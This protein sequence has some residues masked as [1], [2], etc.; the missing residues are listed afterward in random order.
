MK[1]VMLGLA[2]ALSLVA[3]QASAADAKGEIVTAATHAGYASQAANIDGVHMHLHHT[4]N[5]LVGPN[6]AGFDAKELNPCAHSGNGA[7]PDTTDAAKK[8]KLQAAADKAKAGIAAT[9]IAT[10]K[11]D[12]T[13][14]ESM[15]KAD[16]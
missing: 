14:V 15:L 8:A 5:C 6:G 16:E 10:A 3:V 2:G 13:E 1:M 11:K 12:A 9:D 7:I 4:L